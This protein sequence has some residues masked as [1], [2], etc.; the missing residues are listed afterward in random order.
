M[1]ADHLCQ[2][3]GGFAGAGRVGTGDAILQRPTDGWPELQGCHADEHVLVA[4]CKGGL[5]PLHDQVADVEA[6]GHHHGLSEKGVLQLC[7][8]GQVEADRALTDVEAPVGDILLGGEHLL[9][10]VDR[11]GR[12]GERGALR[13]R[14]I[15]QDLGPIGGREELL[16]DEAHAQHGE[17]EQRG[18][19]GDHEPLPA[20][21]RIED[22]VE[23][24]RQAR[25]LAVAVGRHLVTQDVD[26]GQGRKQD[27]DNPRR[28]QGDGDHDEHREAVLTGAALGEAHGNEAGDGDERAGQHRES[29]RGVSERRGRDLVRTLLELLHH[30]LDGDHGV[31]DEQAERDDERTERDALERDAEQVHHHKGDGEHER[32]GDGNND[33]GPPAERQ[34]ADAEHD[35]DRLHQR[36]GELADGLVHDVWLVGD[37]MRL[38]TDRH[39][40]R[41]LGHACLDVPAE[42]LDVAVASHGDG[43]ADGRLAIVSERRLRRI[44]VAAPDGGDVG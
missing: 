12:G 26:A 35:G 21:G 40:T 33:A 22:F 39:I 30:H 27:G 31:V 34:E 24:A 41:N 38:D 28:R 2:I 43:K 14:Q 11:L 5:E 16:L 36:L 3:T 17:D 32:D 9:D 23:A 29:S 6:F 19:R 1:L 15:D 37:Q 10:L 7:V 42:C 20:K 8:E 44:D 13:Q 18:R 25:W 4:R